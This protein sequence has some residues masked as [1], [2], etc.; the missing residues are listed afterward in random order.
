MLVLL[1]ERADTRNYTGERLLRDDE[2][3]GFHGHQFNL[4]AK[5]APLSGRDRLGDA[6]PA[7]CSASHSRSASASD[8]VEQGGVVGLARRRGFM[9]LSGGEEGQRPGRRAS[10]ARHPAVL[11]GRRIKMRVSGRL[12]TRL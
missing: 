2:R 6:T 4:L 7:P 8:R 12:G 3:Q 5:S 1:A 11:Q 10:P 9:S